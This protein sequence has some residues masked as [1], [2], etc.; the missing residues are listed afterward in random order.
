MRWQMRMYRHVVY[1]PAPCTPVIQKV[2]LSSSKGMPVVRWLAASLL[3]VQQ[4]RCHSC[5]VACS[6]VAISMLDSHNH[7]K[8]V[9]HLELA[10]GKHS[11]Q[12]IMERTGRLG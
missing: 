5:V 9:G 7:T 3:C 4:S 6:Q 8:A 10:T 11:T 12:A 1:V 2:F